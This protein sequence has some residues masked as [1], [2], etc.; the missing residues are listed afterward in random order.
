MPPTV[1]FSPLLT[2]VELPKVPLAFLFL[3]V[4]VPY[5]VFV[6]VITLS[7]LDVLMLKLGVLIIAFCRLS[8]DA[9]AD[10]PRVQDV[11]ELTP[12]AVTTLVVKDIAGLDTSPGFP[13]TRPV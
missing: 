3:D 4:A 13:L 8:A 12:D 5:L 7:L 1:I 2:I 9:L 11:P 6:R 10:A